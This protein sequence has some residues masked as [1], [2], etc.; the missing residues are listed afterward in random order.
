[1][2]PFNKTTATLVRPHPISTLCTTPLGK[3]WVWQQLSHIYNI[4]SLLQ[5]VLVMGVYILCVLGL[6]RKHLQKGE[7][8]EDKV[9]L[10]NREGRVTEVAA[11]M[12]DMEEDVMV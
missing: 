6:I 9:I 5:T 4:S 1:M 3:M 12:L 2:R 8:D 11:D 10:I 7:V